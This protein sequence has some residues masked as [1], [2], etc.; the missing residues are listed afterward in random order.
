MER[1]RWNDSSSYDVDQL[2]MEQLKDAI[3]DWAEGSLTLENLLWKSYDM[4]MKSTYS[5]SNNIGY[6][7]RPENMET[8]RKICSYLQERTTGII[9]LCMYGNPYS[10]PNWAHPWVHILDNLLVLEKDSRFADE[11]FN[12]LGDIIT[13]MK[14]QEIK[15]GYDQIFD[16]CEFFKDK[17]PEATVKME[18]KEYSYRLCLQITR[19]PRILKDYFNMFVDSPVFKYMTI[20]EARRKGGDINFC[21]SSRNFSSF[22]DIVQECLVTLKENWSRTIPDEIPQDASGWERA[23]IMR[24]KFGTSPEGIQKMNDWLNQTRKKG[25]REVAY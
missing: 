9:H 8:L 11:L 6:L 24:H 20:E 21:F 1:K 22:N 7:V 5:G 12:D 25:F 17:I 10:G 16:F 3:P 18:M 19:T 2:T 4:G 13:G 15:R 14:E 23:M